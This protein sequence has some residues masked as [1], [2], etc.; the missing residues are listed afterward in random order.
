MVT[1]F[2][3]RQDKREVFTVTVEYAYSTVSNGRFARKTGAAVTT[4]LSKGGLGLYTN[5][6]FN[7]GQNLTI[8]GRQISDDPM[9]AMVRWCS[10]VSES[11]YKIGLMFT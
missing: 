10:R 8:N 2:E 7:T 3:K 11:I 1:V 6:L 4:N 5:Q 9:N